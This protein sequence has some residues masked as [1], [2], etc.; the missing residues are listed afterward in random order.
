MSDSLTDLRLRVGQA[1]SRARDLLEWYL[2]FE[3][4]LPRG[5]SNDDIGFLSKIPCPLG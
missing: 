2:K 1:F 4:R 3:G 5:F